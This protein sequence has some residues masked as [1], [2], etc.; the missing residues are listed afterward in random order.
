V[1]VPTWKVTRTSAGERL[2][3]FLHRQL[4]GRASARAIKRELERGCCTVNGRLTR[5]ASHRLQ[6]GDQV[7]FQWGGDPVGQRRLH[8]DPAAILHEDPRYLAYDKPPGYPCHPTLDPDRPDLHTHL[9]AF[10]RERDG[11]DYLGLVH[12][13]DRDTS[14][15]LLLVKLPELADPITDLFRQR[16]IQKVYLAIAAGLLR[17]R[18]GS[19]ETRIRRGRGPG[20]VDRWETTSRGGRS[21]CTEYEVLRPLGRGACLVRLTPRTGRTHQLRV[22]LAAAGHPIL[23]DLLYGEARAVEGWPGGWRPSRHLLHAQR[24]AF[25]DPVTGTHLTIEAPVPGDLQDAV[26]HLGGSS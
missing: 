14:G 16:Q 1:T 13:L 21:A 24:L 8:I 3:T 11:T 19:W 5:H 26:R 6:A 18:R 25:R 20:G 17:P 2:G 12:R 10:L 9:R 4:R 22:H 7:A 23:G 15:V